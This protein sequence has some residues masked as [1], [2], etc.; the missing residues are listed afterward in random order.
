M[1]LSTGFPFQ[2]PPTWFLRR[3][4]KFIAR[5]QNANAA[6][7]FRA[8]GSS[9][10]ESIS[11]NCKIICCNLPFNFRYVLYLRISEK[12]S[13]RMIS[14]IKWDGDLS[15]TECTVL[16]STDHAS[17]WKHITTA[18]WGRSSKYRPGCLHLKHRWIYI[19]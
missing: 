7:Q 8:S 1:P 11:S 5:Y 12:S 10:C 2:V 6:I 17:L 18:V 3:K 13:T 15:K 16:S 9:W 19:E 4:Q 14:F